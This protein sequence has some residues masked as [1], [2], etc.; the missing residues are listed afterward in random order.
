MERFH[1][2]ALLLVALV[3]PFVAAPR[4][5]FA[6]GLCACYAQTDPWVLADGSRSAPL[7]LRLFVWLAR[8][9]AGTLRFSTAA[10][11]EVP[12]TLS[13]AGREGAFWLEPTELLAPNTEYQISVLELDTVDGPTPLV[14]SFT[15][16]TAEDHVAPVVGAVSYSNEYWGGGICGSSIGGQVRI[17]GIVDEGAVGDPVLAQLDLETSQGPYRL[18]FPVNAWTSTV[19]GDIGAGDRDCFGY[20]TFSTTE[21]GMDYPATLT[22]WDWSGNSTVVAGLDIVPTESIPWSCPTT[23]PPDAGSADAPTTKPRGGCATARNA[24]SDHFATTLAL[25]GALGWL[26]RRKRRT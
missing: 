16:G 19:S 18:F 12:F 11:V 1:R 10:G 13:P 8:M 26:V 5:A 17:E 24:S 22:V 23:E 21:Q 15:T 7:N 4:P 2:T 14:A 6:C 9:D 20:R 25:F 3:V